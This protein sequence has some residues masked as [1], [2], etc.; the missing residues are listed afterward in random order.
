MIWSTKSKMIVSREYALYLGCDFPAHQ[1]FM[2]DN[3][4]L[5]KPGVCCTIFGELKVES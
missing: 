3:C 4:L 2:I 5:T 1:V